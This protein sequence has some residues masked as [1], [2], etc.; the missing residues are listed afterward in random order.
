[1]VTVT[2][3]FLFG[4]LK[5]VVASSNGNGSSLVFL[6]L[7]VVILHIVS[8]YLRSHIVAM[9]TVLLLFTLV[10]CGCYEADVAMEMLLFGSGFY[11]AGVVAMVI[12]VDVVFV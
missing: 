12:G 5:C 4:F 9:A 2:T 1:M 8:S 6:L 7:R 11:E 3:L 10:V